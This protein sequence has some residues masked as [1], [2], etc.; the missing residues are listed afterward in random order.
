MKLGEMLKI[1]NADCVFS[2][3]AKIYGATMHRNTCII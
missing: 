1:G 2:V 3:S